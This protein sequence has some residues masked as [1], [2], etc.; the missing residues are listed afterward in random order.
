MRER[1]AVARAQS[2]FEVCAGAAFSDSLGNLLLRGLDNGD[3]DCLLEARR[4]LA[5]WLCWGKPV[6][7]TRANA[8]ASAVL[9]YMRDSRCG[10]CFGQQFIRQDAA[11]KACGACNGRGHVGTPPH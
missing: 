8:I 2:R 7:N 4:Y 9:A 3:S 11:V 6:G 1:L 10:V 5:E